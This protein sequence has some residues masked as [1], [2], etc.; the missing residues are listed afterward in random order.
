MT[1]ADYSG[2]LPAAGRCI[3][4]FGGGGGT[5]EHFA[6]IHPGARYAH[7]TLEEASAILGEM[8]SPLDCIL[9]EGEA[10]ASLTEEA[11]REHLAHL[12]EDGQ[13]VFVAE[14]PG[15]FRRIFALLSG[16]D[17]VPTGRAPASI[18]RMAESAGLFL[19]HVLPVRSGQD[20]EEEKRPDTR[21]FLAAVRGWQEGRGISRGSDPLALRHVLRFARRRRERIFIQAM[22][23][24]ALVTARV[25]VHEPN[26]F[27]M[28]VPGVEC[29]AAQTVDFSLGAHYPRK[30]FLCQRI[31]FM[32]VR[33]GLANVDNICRAGYLSIAEM[34]DNISLWRKDYETSRYLE[35]RGMH[36]VQTSTE[37]LAEIL[38]RFNP[39]VAVFPNQLRELP[40]P[41]EYAK[42]EAVTVFFGALNRGPD[43]QE[44]M[45]VL[46][47]AAREYGGRLRFRVLADRAFYDALR[48]EHKEFIG[49]EDFYE[50]RYVPYEVYI[51]T[52][53]TADISLLPLRDTEFNRT[54]SDLKFIESAGHGAVVLA[55][56]TVYQGSVR[57]GV[58]GFL[59]RSPGEFAE[60]LRFLVEHPEKRRSVAEA[61]Y[62]YVASERLL[63]GHYEER[64][65]W[66]E[67]LL[68]RKEEL[69]AALRE[70]VAGIQGS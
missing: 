53:R 47:E 37:P 24:E 62:R 61:A 51:D 59:Y 12:A 33:T 46:N 29:R 44:I 52:L 54:K 40:P 30:V 14:N 18:V 48:T 68:A 65:A 50:G 36:A 69:D 15:Y 16:E 2:V 39:E 55:S 38:R 43:W 60:R 66:Y 31:R 28:T 4:H 23:G 9:Y 35:L 57:D 45:P 1:G 8:D 17:F 11:L 3:A 70:R 67:E 26:S 34:D 49:R 42:G 58:T 21:A 5:E 20:A 25:R 10:A 27:L 19:D 32:N 64:L 41:R 6:R 13:V 22:L 63:S 56:P 7:A